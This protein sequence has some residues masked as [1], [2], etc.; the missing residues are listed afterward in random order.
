MKNFGSSS[1]ILF[2]LATTIF[3]VPIFTIPVR[4]DALVVSDYF[5]FVQAYWGTDKLIEVSP[6][7]VAT[8]T[9]VLMYESTYSISNIEANLSL[10]NGFE[11]V[12]G[13]DK[14]ITYYTG[15]ISTGSLVKLTFPIF[16]TRGLEIG[17]YAANLS[18]EFYVS[19]LSFFC[20]NEL[21]VTF[22]VTGK[23][24]INVDVLNET[25]L[26]GKQQISLIISNDGDA[27]AK[28]IKILKVYS[29][30]TSAEFEA[31]LSDAKFLDGLEPQDEITLPLQ[32]DVPTG[33]VGKS[34]PLTVE[35]SYLGPSNVVYEL[36]EVQ[37]LLVKAVEEV[38]A[39]AK[40]PEVTVEAGKVVQYPITITNS[41]DA[42]RLLLLS[43][44]PPTDW[45]AVVKSGTLEISRIYMEAGESE[46]L[47]IEATPP[48]AANINTYQ[49]PVQI[50]SEN[51]D[52]YAEMD[53]KATIVGSYALSL[54][55]STLLTSVTTG[56]SVTFTA[57]VTNTGYTSV[58][59]IG[60]GVSV[61]SGWEASITPTQV[62]SLAPN[63]YYTFTLI[64]TTPGDTVAGDYMITLMGLS[65]QVNSDSVQVRV[66][67]TTPSSWGLIGIGVA[68]V[69]VV[70]LILVFMKFRRR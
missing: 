2:L 51:G 17:G 40:F 11:A 38:I 69:M 37:Q 3:T 13:G 12:G 41:G 8:L 65:D 30:S 25:L 18:L 36:S 29:S 22:E 33:T 57:K 62:T 1:T 16:I 64:A 46:N 34:L 9:V 48:S 31:K 50:K 53:L 26:E 59:D 68:A 14:A 15:A 35:V 19:R 54:E 47:V 63:G 5:T 70:A 20:V 43:V 66:T 44:E 42:D 10:P 58:T 49:I 45:T 4:S 21:E 39:T 23:P 32:V 55:T 24:D 6:G 28:N 52:I 27:I 61:P 67:A 60:V 7:D 56:S